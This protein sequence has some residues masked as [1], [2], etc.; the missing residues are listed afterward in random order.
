MSRELHEELALSP[1]WSRDLD[2]AVQDGLDHV[3]WLTL[4]RRIKALMAA[5]RTPNS[6]GLVLGFRFMGSDSSAPDK[7]SYHIYAV[8]AF[9]VVL[10]SVL[11]ITTD[12]VGPEYAWQQICRELKPPFVNPDPTCVPQM[13]TPVRPGSEEALRVFAVNP[14]E[15]NMETLARVMGLDRPEPVEKIVDPATEQK[16]RRLR[17]LVTPEASWRTPWQEDVMWLLGYVDALHDRVSNARWQMKRLSEEVKTAVQQGRDEEQAWRQSNAVSWSAVPLP[18]DRC[19]HNRCLG[20]LVA[21]AEPGYVRCD[22][23]AVRLGPGP[24]ADEVIE[25]AVEAGRRQ[26]QKEYDELEHHAERELDIHEERVKQIEDIH[27][28]LGHCD[29]E[30]SNCHDLGDCSVQAAGEMVAELHRLREEVKRFSDDGTGPSRIGDVW[31]RMNEEQ[32]VVRLHVSDMA[33]G[34]EWVGM[35]AAS[36]ERMTTTQALRAQ[37]WRRIRRGAF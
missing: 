9:G 10:P 13:M 19:G 32:L 29:D 37:G 1:A 4:H 15:E 21:L 7:I 20:T 5:N 34:H 3:A 8:S 23:C 18:G 12:T 2:A 27:A 36:D 30:W 31:M 28:F 24:G 11:S 16:L 17:A 33:H 35:S 25:A 14:T 6:D 26:M 22:R